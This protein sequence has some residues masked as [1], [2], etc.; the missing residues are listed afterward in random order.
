MPTANTG[1]AFVDR[2]GAIVAADRGFL[3]ALGV[4]GAEG[5]ACAALLARVEASPAL[6]ALVAGDG[7]PVARL[8]GPAGPVE[9]LRTATDG[10]ALLV[11][12]V[13]GDA[14]RLEHAARSLALTRVA[15]GV[16]HD[17]KNPLNAMALQIALLSEKLASAGEAASSAAAAHLGP[18][19]DQ[20]SRV[21]EVVRRLLDVADPSAPLGFT[22]LG[23]LAIDAAALLSHDARRR[24][25]EV[26]L[27]A[28]AGVKTRCDPARV[29]RLVLALVHRALAGT[30]EG[31]R[32]GVR[33]EAD[34]DDVRVVLDHA[35]ADLGGG[36]GYDCD[37]AEEGARALGGH[38]DIERGAD[39][40]RVVLTLPRNRRE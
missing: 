23:A 33:V 7:P 26:A 37:V 35:G 6:R 2:S 18:L 14:E 24:R 31:G 32:L 20:I 34:R 5:A 8:D 3:G 4:D 27:E 39:G 40:H 17:I 15:A 12:G 22:D 36:L 10:G 19:R 25:V 30:P 11:L 13:G 9:V 1:A 28:P 29:G 38:L 21:N 16:A